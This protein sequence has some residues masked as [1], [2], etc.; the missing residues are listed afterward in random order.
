MV[1][2]ARNGVD[3]GGIPLLDRATVSDVKST[4]GGPGQV[5]FAEGERAPLNNQFL[6]ETP[7]EWGESRLNR[8][9]PIVVVEVL[10][11]VT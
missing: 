8:V 2:H 3:S 7:V 5:N 6:L 9:D 11:R 10:Y 4:S 1:L